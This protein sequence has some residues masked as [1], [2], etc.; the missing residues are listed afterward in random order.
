MWR[1]KKMDVV[2]V[3]VVVWMGPAREC[4]EVLNASTCCLVALCCAL[5]IRGVVVCYHFNDLIFDN[6]APKYR[7]LFSFHF[8]LSFAFSYLILCF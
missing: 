4:C 1:E 8:W 3:V 2:V 6:L 7:F 5:F